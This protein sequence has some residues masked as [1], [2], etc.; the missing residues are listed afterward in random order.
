VYY[1][2]YLLANN[3]H[4]PRETAQLADKF[5]VGLNQFF[6]KISVLASLL[7]LSLTVGCLFFVQ[8]F[9]HPVAYAREDLVPGSPYTSDRGAAMGDA[10]LP[11][12]DDA[13]ALFYNPAGLAKIRGVD[14]E[15][16]NFNFYANSGYINH[17]GPGSFYKITSLSASQGNLASNAGNFMGVGGEYFP[18][19]ASHGFAFGV[20]LNNEVGAIANSSGS[21]TYRS[22]YQ[23]IPTAG[24]GLRLA[25][26]IVRIG[27][28]LQWINQASGDVTVPQST[29]NAGYNQ[30]LAQGS[31]FS[32]N[33]G[34]ALTLPYTYLPSLNIVGRNIGGAHFNTSS[35]YQFTP[36]PTGAPPDD[37]FSI[38]SSLSF[39]TKL[40]GGDKI[41]WVFEDR[42]M[43][44][45]S[46]MEF[47]GRM[48]LGSEYIYNNTFYL[49]G[50]WGSGYPAAGIAMKTKQGEFGLSWF[51]EEL[52]QTYH[53]MR[54]ERYMLSFSVRAF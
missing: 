31:A 11:L 12:A 37:P 1:T 22:M 36:D 40:G 15:P 42:D 48:A 46:G 29:A 41:N 7:S 14:F 10:V 49:R 18:S 33:V 5:H 3:H 19:F 21:L 39:V 23:M 9:S 32:N 4:T 53:S 17:I 6:K 43:T 50:G 24:Y 45:T 44:N 25:D 35:I 20:L 51:S 2:G 30:N 54:D 28:S 13:S 47:L 38:D 27:Y 16:F 26:G 8:C 34:F 52:G